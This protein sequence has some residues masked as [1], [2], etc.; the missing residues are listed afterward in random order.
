[1]AY[2]MLKHYE[3]R[4]IEEHTIY[5]SN[6]ELLAKQIKEMTEQQLGKL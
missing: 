4:I 3:R 5:K 2:Y 6:W 1:M